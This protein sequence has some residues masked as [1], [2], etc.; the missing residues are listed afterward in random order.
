MILDRAEPGER[1][2]M[3]VQARAAHPASVAQH[4][5]PQAAIVMIAYPFDRAANPAQ[6]AFGPSDVAQQ[7]PLRALQETIEQLALRHRRQ[8]RNVLGRVEQRQ[9]PQQRV[10]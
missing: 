10:A 2:E 5:D 9:Q 7:S 6:R 1:N 8:R 3:A 4:L